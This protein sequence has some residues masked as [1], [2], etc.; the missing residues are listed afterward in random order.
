MNRQE[1]I[2][3]MKQNAEN[4]GGKKGDMAI[5]VIL[6]LIERMD[7]YWLASH[8]DLDISRLTVLDN[9]QPSMKRIERMYPELL[10][11]NCTCITK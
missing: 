11:G 8:A 4:L 1:I 6:P 10:G 9:G 2:D 7:D 5:R 3:S